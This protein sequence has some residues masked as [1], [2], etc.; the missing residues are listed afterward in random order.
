MDRCCTGRDAK[1]TLGKGQRHRAGAVEEEVAERER[2]RRSNECEPS[3]AIPAEGHRSQ[4]PPPS[5]SRALSGGQIRFPGGERRLRVG[6]DFTA[7]ASAG[8]LR[9]G[10]SST[11]AGNPSAVACS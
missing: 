1:T 2:R 6:G 5:R 11:G 10:D 4:G 3:A 7:A 8:R 9:G